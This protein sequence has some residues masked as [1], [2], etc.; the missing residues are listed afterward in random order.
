MNKEEQQENYDA[1]MQE[2]WN[3]L[4]ERE[5]AEIHSKNERKEQ[6]QSFLKAVRELQ[7]DSEPI[8]LK[9]VKKSLGFSDKLFD[10]VRLSLE[11][12]GDIYRPRHGMVKTTE[13]PF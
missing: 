13:K 9:D 2:E 7:I 1:A 11:Q 3:N 10:V 12:K 5:Q 6:Q 8:F 4:S